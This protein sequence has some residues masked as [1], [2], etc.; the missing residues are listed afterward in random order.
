MWLSAD[1]IGNRFCFY[2][3]PC[4][5]WGDPVKECTCSAQTATLCQKRISGP[6]LDRIDIHIEVPRVNYDKLTEDRMGESSEA[7]Q[8][9]VERARGRQQE[10]FKNGG[11][12]ANADMRPGDVREYCKLDKTG[13][14]LLRSA[15]AYL[16]LT[17]RAYH[18]V[19]KLARTIADL[20]ESEAIQP[21]HIAEAIQYRPRRQ[22]A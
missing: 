21:A 13:T 4:G 15:M 7:I 18:R 20:A 22:N 14:D 2:P 19:L 6:L 5:Y 10:R 12:A 1:S 16:Q 11:L 17:A 9:R 3:C 8:K